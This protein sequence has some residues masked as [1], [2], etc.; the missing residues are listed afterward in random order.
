MSSNPDT[1]NPFLQD[2][3]LVPILLQNKQ[4]QASFKQA[5]NAYKT[6]IAQSIHKPNIFTTMSQSLSH[7][8]RF[9]FAALTAFTLLAGGVAA[10]A[11]APEN[12]KPITVANNLFGANKQK[13]NDP[14]VALMMEEKQY[15]I[16]LEDCGINIKFPKQYNSDN[17][18]LFTVKNPEVAYLNVSSKNENSHSG[19][20][21]E[22]GC[23]SDLSKTTIIS[24][25]PNSIEIL[26]PSQL[27]A[28]TGWFIAQ[29]TISNI[30]KYTLD[31]K[32][33]YVFSLND[34]QYY[35]DIATK[36][37][38]NVVFA[39]IANQLQIQPQKS[40]NSGEV[41]KTQSCFD[42]I[43]VSFSIGE[44]NTTIEEQSTKTII[45]EKYAYK[46]LEKREKD[47]KIIAI[48]CYNGSFE[49]G[50]K[51]L[52]NSI[53]VGALT[54]TNYRFDIFLN[55]NKLIAVYEISS[56]KSNNQPTY[57]LNYNNKLIT[58]ASPNVQ[59]HAKMFNL[60]ID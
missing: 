52:K 30:K 37:G 5:R 9:S 56:N 59:E 29:D 18:V 11:F 20:T 3:A 14:Q 17:T 35:V 41:A 32:D 42:D 36:N 21:M 24:E 54:L 38:A 43:N 40:V 25:S 13:D 51:L 26:T 48:N 8:T 28:Q 46:D 47:G 4:F 15:T 49:E 7:I 6:H 60:K 39:D 34:K 57:I 12:Y 2:D 27:L 44:S 55:Q 1:K 23:S 45:E 33:Q 58:I 10:Q 19:F 53:N 31:G 50:L 16:S 22:L